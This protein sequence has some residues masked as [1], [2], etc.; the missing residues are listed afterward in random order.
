VLFTSV[1]AALLRHEV[2]F[3][4][5]GGVAVVLHGHPRL[6][7][8]LDLVI[9][10]ATAHVDHAVGALESLGLRPRLPIDPRDLGDP[11]VRRTWVEE[12]HLRVVSFHDPDDPFREVDLFADPPVP[13]EELRRR[14]STVRIDDLEVP[15]ASIEDLTAMK[16]LAGRPQD[17]A[18]V[19]ALEAIQR[20][21]PGGGT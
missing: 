13:F 14:A 17:L 1:F 8:D 3:V 20:R 4:V 9:D 18:D 2:P 16:R 21:R 5:V 15:V 11:A 12:R 7:A 10:L 19:A 6:T